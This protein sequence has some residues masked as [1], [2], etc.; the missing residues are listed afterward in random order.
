MKQREEGWNLLGSR[1]DLWKMFIDYRGMT[2]YQNTLTN[3][4]QFERPP[5]FYGGIIADPVGLGRTLTVLS[6]IACNLGG[7]AEPDTDV[8]GLGMTAVEATLIVVPFPLL[9]VWENQIQQHLHSSAQ[10]LIFPWPQTSFSLSSSL[11]I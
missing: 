7:G 9:F 3:R 8:G 2:K 1:R 5:L 10:S 4:T 11:Q 6:L